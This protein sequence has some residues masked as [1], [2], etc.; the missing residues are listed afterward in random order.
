[1]TY[2]HCHCTKYFRLKFPAI[3]KTKNETLIKAKV[4]QAPPLCKNNKKQM[5][6]PQ[7]SIRFQNDVPYFTTI[8]KIR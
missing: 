6:N 2:T 1:M 4:L 8:P 5:Q 3:L 7:S